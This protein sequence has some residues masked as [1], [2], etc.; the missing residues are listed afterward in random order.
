M[1]MHLNSLPI[2]TGGGIFSAGMC[3]RILCSLCD[4]LLAS[5]GRPA[6]AYVTRDLMSLCSSNLIM[7][8]RFAM[9]PLRMV[10]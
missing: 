5:R 3:C 7:Y 1:H 2:A 4:I 8:V 10:L 6:S 9:L